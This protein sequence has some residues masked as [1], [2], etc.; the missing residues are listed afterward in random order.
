[1]LNEL[2]PGY[3]TTCK[4][5]KFLPRSSEFGFD[6]EDLNMSIHCWK[7]LYIT[8]FSSP[9]VIYLSYG[10]WGWYINH[11]K[12]PKMGVTGEK[13]KSVYDGCIKICRLSEH[14]THWI[15]L[16]LFLNVPM[17]G[18][19]TFHC[20]DLPKNFPNDALSPCTKFSCLVIVMRVKI[21]CM[22]KC[23]RGWSTDHSS[24]KKAARA[25]MRA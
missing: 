4:I 1:M 8:H 22:N 14:L 25:C 13:M 9:E 23:R 24:N 15:C 21:P 19:R 3:P 7:S 12:I 10:A 16:F 20:N 6:W 11:Y 17:V 18:W 5:I 2:Y